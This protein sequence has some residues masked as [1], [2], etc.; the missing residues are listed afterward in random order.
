[1]NPDLERLAE[2]CD[3]DHAILLDRAALAKAKAAVSAGEAAVAA[4]EKARDTVQA[5]MDRAKDLERTTHRRLEQYRKRAARAE[6][7][8]ETG[9]G[10]LFA[11]EKQL[12]QCTDII[13]TLETE[14]LEALEVEEEIQVRLDA[15]SEKVAAAEGVLARAREESPGQVADLQGSLATRLAEREA[16]A[17]PLAHEL[18]SRYELLRGRK[19]PAVAKISGGA[20]SKCMYTFPQQ[21]LIELRRGEF[22]VCRG[23]GRWLME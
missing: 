10:D 12:A 13:D 16:L 7:V 14:V 23:C 3:V 17:A 15:A 5:E 11:A 4:A 2:L 21:K 6:E 22:V 9:M 18:I 19:P 8:L 20:C 1:M